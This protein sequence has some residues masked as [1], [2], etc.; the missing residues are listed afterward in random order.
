ARGRDARCVVDTSSGTPRLVSSQAAPRP[1][2]GRPRCAFFPIPGAPPEHRGPCLD[3]AN[4]AITPTRGP[5]G[6]Q[7]GIAGKV[8]PFVLVRRPE[9][10]V[11]WR[12]TRVEGRRARKD[13]GRSR[14]PQ[15]EMELRKGIMATQESRK[16]TTQRQI[17]RA[18]CREREERTGG[19][20]SR[21]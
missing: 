6:P 5:I 9:H 10:A 15:A 18:S 19:A 13:Q 12:R 20:A 4:G 3:P 14:R 7:K 8:G 2:L 21:R 1:L 16:V 11:I 17:G